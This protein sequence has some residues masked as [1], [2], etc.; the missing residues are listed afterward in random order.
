M[1]LSEDMAGI[2]PHWGVYFTVE[3]CRRAVERVR[4][5]GGQVHMEPLEMGFGTFAAVADPQGASFSLFS[6]QSDP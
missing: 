5:L 1:A 4:E 2:P 6:G 3:D